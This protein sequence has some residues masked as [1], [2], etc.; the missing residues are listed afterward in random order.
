[1]SK[2]HLAV[3]AFIL[4]A[5]TA[6]FVGC[7]V[8]L[9]EGESLFNPVADDGAGGGTVKLVADGGDYGFGAGVGGD[10]GTASGG[11]NPENNGF[12]N[13]AMTGTVRDFR[14]SHP[15]FEYVKATDP[16]I[17]ELQLGADGKPVYAAGYDGTASTHGPETFDQWFRDVPGINQ[18]QLLTLNF[19]HTGNGVYTY[20]NSAFFPVDY[21]LFG[22]EAYPHNYHFTFEL[23]TKFVYHGGEVF[24][25]TGDDDLFTYINH[26]LVIDLGGVHPALSQEVYLDA[27]ADSLGLEVGGIYDLDLFFAERHT[28][29]SN[30][31]ID[32]T[33]SFV[34]CGP[35]NPK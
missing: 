24:R 19:V 17:V 15:D 20:D 28:S 31:R 13:T 18:S 5:A 1:M 10:D 30:F 11:G 25:F 6:S 23:H 21:Q 16:G 7:A 2:T 33:I 32:T 8:G 14:Q 3:G 29:E 35:E 9:D 4:A 27:V 12:C 34:D 26:R 22:N